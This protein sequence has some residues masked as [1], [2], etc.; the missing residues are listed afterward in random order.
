M[1]IEDIPAAIRQLRKEYI[2]QG[3]AP[4][5]YEINNGLCDNFTADLIASFNHPEGLW[6]LCNQ[7]FTMDDSDREWDWA[8][9]EKHWPNIRAPKGLSHEEMDDLEFGYH[10]F[11]NCEDRF[12]DAE[13]PDGVKNFFDLPIFRR[14][15]VQALRSKGIRAD[16]VMP[17]DVVTP[18]LCPVSNPPRMKSSPGLSL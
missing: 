1:N 17:E 10:V 14:V 12:Y 18:P 2:D 7:N 6:D 11:I 9:L 15:I 3:L 16:E 8:L 13:C 4:S 5:Y